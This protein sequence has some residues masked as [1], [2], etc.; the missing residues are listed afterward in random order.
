MGPFPY[1]FVQ[2]L[3]FQDG[4]FIQ[5]NTMFNERSFISWD[6]TNEQPKRTNDEWHWLAGNTVRIR[7]Q[8]GNRQ[9][10]IAG[11]YNTTPVRATAKEN[12]YEYEQSWKSDE[13]GVVHLALPPKFSVDISSLNG[14][15]PFSAKF[16][17][18]RICLDWF[19]IYGEPSDFTI[20]LI[21]HEEAEFQDRAEEFERAI[22]SRL[23]NTEKERNAAAK[24]GISRAPEEA[25]PSKGSLEYWLKIAGAIVALV[26]GVL[27]AIPQASSFLGPFDYTAEAL[28]TL[29]VLGVIAFGLSL[30]VAKPRHPKRRRI[31]VAVVVVA[32]LLALLF[33]HSFLRLSPTDEASVQRD[34]ALGDAELILHNPA[35]AREHYGN[36]AII[37]PRRG[38]IRAKM[39]D[40]ET[41]MKSKGE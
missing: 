31:G 15:M 35:R 6:R 8:Q 36:A 34:V 9:I 32:P 29:C 4:E 18:G 19:T 26:S 28:L 3:K 5:T 12:I 1:I 16:D 17:R 22:R 30:I 24:Y 37:A 2:D 11:R 40:A 33:W 20:E 27:V 13:E 25:A 21:R 39:Q 14:H 41:R 23:R 38:S 7:R 10:E